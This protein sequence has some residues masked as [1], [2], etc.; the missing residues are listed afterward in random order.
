MPL[1]MKSSENQKN[2]E[3]LLGKYFS[4]KGLSPK[5]LKQYKD[6]ITNQVGSNIRL[7]DLAAQ[8]RHNENN[9]HMREQNNDVT[10]LVL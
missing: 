8:L 7:K 10:G 1:E 4:K 2:Y 9:P 6:L 3:I 5:E